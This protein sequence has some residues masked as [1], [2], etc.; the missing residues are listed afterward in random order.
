MHTVR[1]DHLVLTVASI[2]ATCEFYS[3]VLGMEVV[4]FGEGR[5]ALSFGNQ[6]IN[7]HQVGREFEPKANRPTAGSADLC[8]IVD[9]GNRDILGHLAAHQIAVEAGPVV[10]T[11]ATGPIRSVYVRDPDHNLIELSEYIR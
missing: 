1:I 10:R 6:K 11:G 8:L 9:P 2:P 7:L 5:T 3:R 4:T